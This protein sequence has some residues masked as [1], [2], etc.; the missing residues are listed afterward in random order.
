MRRRRLQLSMQLRLQLRRGDLGRGEVG[1][2][3][4][5][6]GPRPPGPRSISV[7]I[8]ALNEEA[9]IAGAVAS[10]CGR[11]GATPGGPRRTRPPAAVPGPG[12]PARPREVIV[13]DGGS[14]DR[15]AEVAAALGARVLRAGQACRGRQMNV[16][17]RAAT[18]DVLVFLHGDALLPQGFE[19]A[20]QREGAR[21]G[22]GACRALDIRARGPGFRAVELGARVR[23]CLMG[24]P[25]GDQCLFVE[26]QLFDRVG[27]F[28]EIPLMEDFDLAHRLR[29][30]VP[31]TLLP[32]AMPASP[33][34]WERVGPMRA[35]ALNQVLILAWLLGAPPEALA[36]AYYRGRP[37]RGV[38]RPRLGHAHR[39]RTPGAHAG[40]GG[41]G[42]WR[43][44]RSAERS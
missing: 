26:R 40:G 25:Y 23:T 35:V 12:G 43:P 5:A 36:D 33:R 30:V 24:L 15:T 27:G 29:R 1:R 13:V 3:H 2:R 18:G 16:G 39:G 4:R 22:W 37:L 34:R 31:P 8:P 42:G 17:A 11:A 6:A 41:G 14:T 21:P 28:K 44:R 9:G 38:W 19:A 7:V 32:L 20:L 10:A